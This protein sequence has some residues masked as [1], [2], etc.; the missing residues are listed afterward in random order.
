[1]IFVSYPDLGHQPREDVKDLRGQ[2]TRPLCSSSSFFLSLFTCLKVGSQLLLMTSCRR[3]LSGVHILF[4]F[5]MPCG[6]RMVVV[7]PFPLTPTL[8][9]RPGSLLLSSG[10]LVCSG[11]SGLLTFLCPGLNCLFSFL[12]LREEPHMSLLPRV[13]SLSPP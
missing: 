4:H 2:G 10:V 1:M 12:S 3:L 11:V 13:V 7:F 9:L 5:V 6:M 8:G